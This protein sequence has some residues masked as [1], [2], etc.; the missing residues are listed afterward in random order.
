MPAQGSQ[1]A[2]IV[3]VLLITGIKWKG[4]ITSIRFQAS[5]H[6]RLGYEMM[7]DGGK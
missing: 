4:S 1:V 7:L 5:I 6:A 3:G 2:S